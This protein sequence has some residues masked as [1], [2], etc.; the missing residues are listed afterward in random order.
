M[1]KNTIIAFLLVGVVLF[2]FSWLNRPTPEQLEAQQRYYDSIQ[3]VSLVEQARELTQE[4]VILEDSAIRVDEPDSAQD[5]RLVQ[6]YGDFFRGAKGSEEFFVLENELLELTLSNKGGQIVSARLKEFQTHDSLPLM[7]FDRKEASLDFILKTHNNR[8]INTKQMFFEPIRS[9]NDKSLSFRLDA[10]QGRYLDFTYTLEPDSYMVGFKVAGNGMDEVLSSNTTGLDL[11][12]QQVIRRQ[13][14]GR[15]FEERYTWTTY[16]YMTG[17][18]ERTSDSKDEEVNASGRVHWVGYKDQFFSSVLIS[19]KAPLEAVVIDQKISQKE[20]VLKSCRTSALVSFDLAEK[21]TV[22][23]AFFFGPNKYPLLK[24]YDNLRGSDNKLELN[25]LVSLGPAAFR[26]INAWVVIPIFDFLGNYFA[27]FGLIIFIL[28]LI[29]KVLL[30][31]LTYKS[32]MSTAKMRVLKPQVEEITAKYPGQE[33]AMERQ[34]ATMELYNK[35]GASP[36]SGCLPMLLQMPVWYALFSF[37]PSSIELRQQSFLWANDLSTYDA[38]FSWDAQIPFV[39]TYFGNHISLF[40]LLMAITNMVY[41]QFNMAQ[42]NTGQQQMPGMKL[43]MYFFPI[44]MLVWFNQYPAALSYYF[45]ISSLITILQTLF[46]RWIVNEEKLLAKLEANKKKPK[47]KSGFMAR[48][49]EAQRRQM[50]EAK[51]QQGKKR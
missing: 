6:R 1:D 48:L 20:E 13:E 16:K 18:I 25:R 26:W 41:T 2:G 50:E 38:I 27:S 8:V 19:D 32:Y 4:D 21:E 12:W 35:A 23:L 28:T 9:A 47:K 10:G 49:E 36:M 14:K 24:S 43:M 30:F 33:K 44:M 11:E 7:L 15:K 31:P 39:S 40:C 34:K 17:D 37:F 42:T 51:K 5:A 46:C 3:A 22:E 45:F 29:I